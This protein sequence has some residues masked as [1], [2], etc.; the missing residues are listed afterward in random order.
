MSP[1]VAIVGPTATGKSSLALELCQALNGEII[2]ADSRQV[3]RYMDIGTAKPTKEEQTLVPHHLIDVVN[4]D[5]HFSLA[6]YQSK[7]LEVI[8]AIRRREK[9]ALL[10]GG[11]GLYVWALLEGWRIPTVPPNHAL[12]QKLEA[13][14]KSEGGEALYKKLKEIDPVAAERIDPKNIR[15]VIRAL[16]VSLQGT[17]FS[18]LQVKKPFVDS[19]IIGL[20]TDR[21]NLYRRIDTRVDNM[22][23]KGLVAEVEGLMARGY[24]FALPSMS[25]LGYKQIGMY[26]QGKV[27]PL[28]A[29]QQ[30]KFDTHS[31]A[32]HQY[33]WFRLKDKR[34]NWFELG[35]GSNQN[36]HRFVQ[37][38]VVN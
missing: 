29:V 32:R 38:F 5:E 20:T 27:D 3:Y 25:G 36:I 15:R 26:L 35:E 2:S 12:R 17:L 4:P 10:V 11:S 34:I 24:G 33:N 37:R 23:K 6:L 8:E 21:D 30:I 9:T 13:R 28:T 14:A 7:A 16:E 31:F 22:V 19:V 18:Q 1:L